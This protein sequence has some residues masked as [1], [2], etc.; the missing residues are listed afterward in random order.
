MDACYVL[1]DPAGC[2]G[3]VRINGSL[4][5]SGAGLPGYNTNLTFRRAEGIEISANTGYDLGNWGAIS[6]ST[7]TPTTT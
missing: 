7:S 6:I 2:A 4:A 1:A 5:T 3:I